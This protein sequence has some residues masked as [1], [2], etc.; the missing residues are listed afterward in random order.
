MSRCFHCHEPLAGSE[1][2]ARIDGRDEPVCCPGCRAVVE[3]IGASGLADYYRHRTAAAARPAANATEWQAFGAPEVA[4]TFVTGSGNE[5]SA[6]LDIDGLHCSA[7]AWLIDRTLRRRSGIVDVSINAATGRGQVRWNA[8][9]TTLID[10]LETIARL[11]YRPAPVA[12]GEVEERRRH[13]R[14]LGLKRLM[15]SAFGMMQVMMFAVADYTARLGG[16]T[17]D[18]VML[19]YFTL[20]SLLVATPVLFYAG[21]PFLAS[22]LQSLRARAISMD[23]PASLALVLAYGASVLN[24]LRGSGEV[25][26]DSVTMFV[27]FLTLGRWVQ[28]TVRHRTLDATGALAKQLPTLA[29]RVCGQGIEDVPLAAL[30]KDDCVLV[31][32]GE[33]VPADGQ[34]LDAAAELNE[35]LLT[36]ESLPVRRQ[37]GDPLTAG[38]INAG[39]PLRLKVTATGEQTVLARLAGLLQEAAAR[40][41][42]TARAADRAA[43]VFLWLV[44]AGAASTCAAWLWIDP[45]RAFSATLAVLV[46]ACPCAFAIASPAAVS[47]AIARLARQGLLVTRPEALESLA[48]VHR[49]VF[50]KTGTLTQ[51]RVQLKQTTPLAN[52][53]EERCLEIAASLE[54]A[55][56]HPLARAFRTSAP[57]A[58]ADE[59]QVLAGLGIEGCVGG[60]RYRIGR[61]AWASGSVSLASEDESAD[62]TGTLVWLGNGN[63]ALAVFELADP[64]RREAATA[65][66]AL[67]RLGIDS[68]LVS[69][70]RAATVAAVASACGIAR[71]MARCSPE[72]KVR[73]IRDME[74]DGLATAMVGDGLNDAPVLGAARVSIA[75]GAGT[76]LAQASADMVLIADDLTVLPRSVALARRMLAIA[77]QNL[78]WAMLYN[79]S[80]LP[81][82]ACGFIP[83]WGAA[84][85]M[86]LSSILVILNAARLLPP[87]QARSAAAE[88]LPPRTEPRY[89]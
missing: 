65:V 29:H 24:G 77:R 22:A 34:L 87:H 75:M 30:T 27:F 12:A 36:G 73:I 57:C 21:A 68:T 19:R 74:T 70:D 10:I 23:V 84:L 42:A 85:G 38:T 4:R 47:A 64:V 58:V 67:Q 62:A 52:L 53:D 5:Q 6:V 20:V 82:A 54:A 56:E 71:Y 39:Q 55:S 63:R 89:A 72:E 33:L 9:A 76:V 66:T 32:A 8:D 2:T 88:T 41:P 45:A 80:C 14:H 28:M 46:V 18:P 37:R 43:A 26:F 69:G 48:Q 81:L 1:I 3:L 83:P 17:I 31:R 78:N 13:E 40:K 61:R 44:L 79:L 49:F 16:E 7:C 25:Y 86:S 11:G 59:V 15:V 51:G 35:A 50:D 60:K